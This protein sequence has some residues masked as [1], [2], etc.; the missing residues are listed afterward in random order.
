MLALH[1]LGNHKSDAERIR[2][3]L[4]YVIRT[5]PLLSDDPDLTVGFELL[6]AALLEDACRYGMPLEAISARARILRSS[7][8]A[9]IPRSVIYSPN[10]SVGHSLEFLGD[11]LD[12]SAARTLQVSNGS[13][14]ATIATTAY[15]T[16]QTGDPAAMRYLSDCVAAFGPENIPYGHPADLWASIW[17][18]YNLHIGNLSPLIRDTMQSHLNLIERNVGQ[19][20]LSW[21]SLV[22]YGDADDT[23]VGLMLL[24]ND[25][26]TV[27]WQL[28]SAY[29][30]QPCF[31]TYRGETHPSISANAHVLS[32]MTGHR[33]AFSDSSI[34]K[35]IAFLQRQQH[36]RGYWTDKW[37]ASPY[38]ATSRA[39]RA[40]V[41]HGCPE[42]AERAI[43]WILATQRRDGMWGFYQ[44]STAE[45]TAYCIHAL[46]AWN[47]AKGGVP[48]H[49]FEN[50]LQ[51][52]RA[53][54]RN[55]AKTATRMWIEKTL[56]YPAH[57][58][59]AA[60]LAAASLCLGELAP[61]TS[62]VVNH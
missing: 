20:G 41:E 42:S 52:I 58:V 61:L 19:W 11:D 14:G 29:E 31:V 62:P 25:G 13:I 21:S 30:E 15:F 57:I 47:R 53:H 18:L 28:L 17:V 46:A 33:D 38:Y 8:L 3:A 39:I 34:H 36:N 27:D 35:V 32:A 54:L 60:L 24:A 51:D 56:Y 16:R 40:L 10:L 4:D 48:R 9:K 1:E 7:K 12:T 43:A 49:I 5:W 2:L 55:P 44:E 6:A 59:H 37:H 22:E 23:A 45:E 26:R 50:G